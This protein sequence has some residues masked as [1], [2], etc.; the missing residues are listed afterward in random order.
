MI[1]MSMMSPESEVEAI[2]LNSGS[3]DE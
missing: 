2:Y 3:S 1:Y